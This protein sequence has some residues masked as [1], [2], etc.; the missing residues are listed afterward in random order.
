MNNV[1]IIHLKKVGRGTLP[2][3]YGWNGSEK[4][5]P[6][7]AH[8]TTIFSWMGFRIDPYNLSELVS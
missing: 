6:R 7:K 8:Q 1:D 4:T 2:T 5:D 3:V